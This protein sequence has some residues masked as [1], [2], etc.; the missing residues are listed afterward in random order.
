M[1]LSRLVIRRLRRLGSQYYP[2]YYDFDYASWRLQQPSPAIT[3]SVAQSPRISIIV[4][5]YNVSKALLVQALESVIAQRYQNWQLCLVNDGADLPHVREVLDQYAASDPRIS[6]HHNE[7]NR[8]ISATSNFALGLA[9]GDFIGLLD[10]DDLLGAEALWEVATA[11]NRNPGAEVFYSDEDKV[12][13]E[14]R[15]SS[16]FFKPDFSPELLT[17]QNYFGHFVVISRSLISSV[18]GFRSQYDGAQDYDLILR[19][20]AVAQRVVHIPKVLYHW[21]QIPGS[22]AL[23][24]AEKGYAWHAGQAALEDY[25]A[26][27]GIDVSVK[28]GVVPGS[29]QSNRTLP[30]RPRVS[31]IIPFRDQPALLDQCLKSV[32]ELTDWTDLE[33]LCINNQSTNPAIKDLINLWQVTDSRIQFID[34]DYEFNFSAICNFAVARASGD[35]V[36]LLNN[37][38]K[39]TSDDWVEALLQYAVD[40][41]IGAVGAVLRYPDNSVQHAG[42]VIGIGGSAGHAFKGFGEDQIGYFGRLHLTS[43]VSAVTAALLMVAKSK[44][45]SVGG[46]D[47]TNF[48]VA[49]NDVDFCLKLQHAGYRNV[50]TAN[51]QGVHFESASRGDE[52]TGAKFT[53]YQAEVQR[54][55]EKWRSFIEQ[56]DSCYNPNL[57]LDSEDYR[58]RW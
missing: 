21:R 8:G 24:Y 1:A 37:D 40:T 2:G 51:C 56:G 32:T 45:Q 30:E 20:T 5:V 16:P 22:T 57:T 7:T 34:F 23:V 13:P 19:A 46:L 35:Y 42:I 18:G 38:V 28:K 50:V 43:N 4:P 44:Y 55:S 12:D 6:V 54:F 14:G 48:A 58:L 10:H 17:S 3:D 39:I 36:V 26:N 11:I 15:Y 29:Y 9:D 31:I 33:I 25:Y 49:L 47:E 53:R 52:H 41:E 27:R